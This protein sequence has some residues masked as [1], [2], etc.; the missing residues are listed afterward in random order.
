MTVRV[1][2]N[3]FGSIGRRALRIAMCNPEVEVVAVND[4]SDP[5]TLGHLLKYDSSYGTWDAEIVCC[6]DR[7]IVGGKEIRIYAEK[8]PSLIPWGENRVDVV[9]ESTGVFTDGKK[10]AAHLQAGA[11][12]V[13]ISAPAKNHDL[14]VVLGVNEDR[15]DPDHHHII[16]N[17]SC[18]TNCLAP[19]AMVLDRKFGIVNGLMCTVHSYTND[20]QIL[21][22]PHKDWRR[23]RSASLAI[24]PTTTGA[25][26]AVAEVLPQLKGKLNGMAMRVPTPAVSV[27]DFTVH[28]KKKATADEINAAFTEA[29]A[30]YLKGIMTVCTEPL[31]SLDFK[32]MPQSVAID[33]LS[34][35]VVG[36]MAKVI[37]W[38]DNEWGYA[39][40]IVELANYVMT[41][42]GA[43]SDRFYVCG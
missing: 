41:A 16:S 37:G 14:T 15:Y 17:A 26:S 19:M 6:P 23:A 22:S 35:Q 29:A 5:A 43:Q 34:T 10:A 11:K 8:D 4:L 36:D 21:D 12:K 2:I 13:L 39:A 1:G 40:R 38:Y 33:S 42:A 25:A 27:V 3:G 7:L 32:G 20:Q 9:I 28:L 24:I 31:V 18:T 30:T